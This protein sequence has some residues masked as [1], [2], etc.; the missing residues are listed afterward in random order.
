LPNFV[1]LTF[2][3]HNGQIFK[4]HTVTKDMI[5]HKFGEFFNTRAKYVFKKKK[6]KKK[7]KLSKW[8]KK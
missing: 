3:I 4:D 7:N 2:S 5:G 6:Q 8:G 1:G